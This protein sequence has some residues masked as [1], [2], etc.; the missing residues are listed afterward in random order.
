MFVTTDT[1]AD[2]GRYETRRKMLCNGNSFET[3][4]Q[5]GIPTAKCTDKSR[6]KSGE[7]SG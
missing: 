2:D 5:N 6:P 1:H 4:C 7:S 3:Y